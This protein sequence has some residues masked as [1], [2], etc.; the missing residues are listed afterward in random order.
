MGA[1]LATHFIP[2]SGHNICNFRHP[3]GHLACFRQ[4]E[5]LLQHTRVPWHIIGSL[6]L[7]QRHVR[8]FLSCLIPTLPNRIVFF[9]ITAL[10][11]FYEEKTQ[12]CHPALTSLPPPQKPNTFSQ[13]PASQLRDRSFAGEAKVVIVVV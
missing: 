4:M 12:W 6:R 13:A 3:P 8:H 9:A 11:L 5:I 7:W 10:P 1:K 2:G